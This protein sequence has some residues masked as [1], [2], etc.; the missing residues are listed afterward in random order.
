MRR[1]GGN[2]RFGVEWMPEKLWRQVLAHIP[3]PCVDVILENSN[4][5]VSLGWRRIPQYANVWVLLEGL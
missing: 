2:A 4:G 1:D 3:I 5:E